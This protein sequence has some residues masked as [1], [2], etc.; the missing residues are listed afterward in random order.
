MKDL[1]ELIYGD[2]DTPVP[3]PATQKLL[4]RRYS[5]YTVYPDGCAPRGPYAVEAGD[6]G[7]WPKK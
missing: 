1:K 5:M 6:K 7:F 3:M 2:N 4:A